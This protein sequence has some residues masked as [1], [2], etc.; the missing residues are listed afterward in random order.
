MNISENGLNLIKKEEGF[1]QK[2]YV[3]P[4][5]KLTIGYGHVILPNESFTEINEIQATQLLKNDVAIAEDCINNSVKVPITQDQFDALISF[6][7]NV[8]RKAFLEST[9]LRNLNNHE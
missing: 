3:C 8:G 7:F 4:A 6:V 5:G 2:P 9:L 1:K